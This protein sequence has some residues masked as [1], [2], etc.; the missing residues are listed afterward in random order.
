MILKGSQRGSG[1]NLAAHLMRMED[2]EH[3]LIHDLRGFASDDLHGAFKEAEA[4]SRSTR[5]RQYLFSLSLNPP[6]DANAPLESF[7][8]AIEKIEERLGLSGQ[9]RAVVVHE[10]EG[11]RHMHCVWS[12]IDSETMTARPLPF[13][14]K[15]MM[16]ISRDLY[17]EHGW[18]MP[19]G[20]IEAAKRNPTNFT[21]AE[22]QQA[23]RQ[24]I[25]PRWIKQL[26]QDCWSRS[27]SAAAF[28]GALQEHGFTLARGDR[29]G[30]VLVDYDGSVHSL[31][32]TLNVTAKDIRGRLGDGKGLPNASTAQRTI[33]VRMSPTIRR[34]IAQAR[35]RFSHRAAHL[36]SAKESMTREHREQRTILAQQ[37]SH[38][39][40]GETKARAERLPKGLRGLWHRLTG[41]YQ[42]VRRENELEAQA[43]LDRHASE[44]AQLIDR[45]RGERARLQ[46]AIR[47]L[48]S[49][50]AELLRDLRRDVGRY[51]HL[52]RTLGAPQVNQGVRSRGL[53]LER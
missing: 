53:R 11:R 26:V 30:F 44:R 19:R 33:A 18:E 49:R 4:I 14:K 28:Q 17:L 10:K 37:Q 39:W 12:R 20:M 7:D 21:L 25:D 15:K 48:R 27:D 22:W 13:F 50:Q 1:Q 51:F 24:G 29:R 40:L 45:Q 2:N 8:A 42:K 43:T 23:K 31:S 9:P 35:E 32:R 5:C 52:S 47:H 46:T 41:Q 6:A 16:E 36:G 34:H 38:Q 3:V